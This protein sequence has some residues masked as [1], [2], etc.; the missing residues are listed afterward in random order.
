VERAKS[1]FIQKKL[2]PYT[3]NNLKKIK[4]D[5]NEMKSAKK[6]SMQKLRGKRMLMKLIFHHHHNFNIHCFFFFSCTKS[7]YFQIIDC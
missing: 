2:Y 6:K 3:V 1:H 5:G 4:T 7:T